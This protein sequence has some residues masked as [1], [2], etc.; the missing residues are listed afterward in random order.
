MGYQQKKANIDFT[1]GNR[2]NKLFKQA[3]FR[4]QDDVRLWLSYIKFCKQV[5]R[6]FVSIVKTSFKVSSLIWYRLFSL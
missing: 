6:I 5:V 1:I 2:V 3:I 4:F